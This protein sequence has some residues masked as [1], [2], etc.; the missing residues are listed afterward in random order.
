MLEQLI[1]HYTDGNK[2]KFAAMVGIKPQ[3]L[4][5]W[6][7]RSTFDAEQL[8][9]GCNNISADWLLSGKGKMTY[10]SQSDNSQ[11]VS[12]D[13]PELIALCKALV[14][15]Y[16]QRDDVMNKLVSMVNGKK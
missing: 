6:L 1:S 8:Y 4:S 2:A 15:N 9:R 16:Q 7:N 10:N 11:T 5:N 3:L 12:N 14:D 13:N